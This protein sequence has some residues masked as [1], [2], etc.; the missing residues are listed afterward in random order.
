VSENLEG[1]VVY[2]RQKV[3]A[4]PAVLDQV[5]RSM[6]LARQTQAN[7][8]TELTIAQREIHDLRIELGGTEALRVAAI[9]RENNAIAERDIARRQTAAVERL[10]PP[11]RAI[12]WIV[13]HL[14]QTTPEVAAVREWL[15]RLETERE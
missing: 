9:E 15:H 10:S 4:D 6:L 8:E 1:Q 14:K 3:N 11:M 12:Y 5:I 2:W 13:E 7:A